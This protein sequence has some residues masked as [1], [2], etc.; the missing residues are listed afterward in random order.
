MFVTL[1]T[2]LSGI[3]TL[4]AVLLVMYTFAQAGRL[5]KGGTFANRMLADSDVRLR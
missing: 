5:R 1:P 4:L 3:S 2:L